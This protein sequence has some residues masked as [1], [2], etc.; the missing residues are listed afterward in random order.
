LRKKSLIIRP[1]YQ[2]SHPGIAEHKKISGADKKSP[3]AELPKKT[4]P[5]VCSR[6]KEEDVLNYKPSVSRFTAAKRRA[7]GLSNLPEKSSLRICEISLLPMSSWASA[8]SIQADDS[9]ESS[10]L[11]A[12]VCRL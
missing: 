11:T 1:F 6:K 8:F 9:V 2:I 4:D 12:G 3:F 10:S 5:K 7:S